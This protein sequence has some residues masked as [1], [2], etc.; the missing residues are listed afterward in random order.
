MVID[1]L[2]LPIIAK[3]LKTKKEELSSWLFLYFIQGKMLCILGKQKEYLPSFAG[4][5]FDN[6]SLVY[7]NIV[8]YIIFWDSGSCLEIMW[9]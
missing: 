8:W 7:H 1:V 6:V 2:H 9:K 5:Y 4:I 3:R